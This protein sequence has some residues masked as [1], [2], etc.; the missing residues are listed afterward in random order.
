MKI[1]RHK[2][3]KKQYQKLS[4]VLKDKTD[5]TLKLFAKNPFNMV[6]KNHSLSGHLTGKRA[7]SVTGNLRIIF[8][9]YNNYTVVLMLNT[10]T[11]TQVYE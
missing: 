7:I 10:G 8:E 11:H 2:K 6:L 1:Y 9:E 5:A 4:P 3:F